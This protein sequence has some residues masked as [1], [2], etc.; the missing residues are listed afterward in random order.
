[1]IEQLEPEAPSA[2]P[3]HRD[4]SPTNRRPWPWAAPEIPP[5]PATLPGGK[6][7]P[8][9][10]VVTPS[11]NQGQFI[12]QT[13]LSVLNQNYPNLEFLVV[14][15]GS[16]DQT[17]SVVE[18][19]R[20]R[21]SYF[22]SEKDK[23][24]SNA[25]NKGFAR[26]TGEILTWL[27]SDDML[28]PDALAAMALAFHT[29]GADMVA[30][31]CSQHIDGKIVRRDM[32][33][34][35]DGIL[36]LDEILDI[37]GCWLRGQF[38]HQP[39]VMFTR[40]LWERAGAHVDE[41][42]FYS[43]DYEL[44]LRFAEQK[45]RLHPI[46]RSI[47]LYRVHEDQKSFSVGR[48]KPEL[49]AVRDSYLKRTGR[50]LKTHGP[51][52]H[53]LPHLRIVMFNDLGGVGGAGIGHQRLATALATAGHEVIPLA[54]MPDLVS[55]QLS[56]DKILAAI[57]ETHPN[58]VVVGNLHAAKLEPG[59][60][61][62]IAQRW[63][64]IQV[65]HDFYSLTGRCAYPGECDK[66]IAGCD[67]TC[68]TAHEYPVLE[69]RLIRAAWEKKNAAMI[70][71]KAPILAAVSDWAE[72]VV[73]KRFENGPRVI[74]LRNGVPIDI[75]KPRDKT[76]C[77]EM[78][79]LPQ[80]RFIVLFSA[81]HLSDRRKGLHHLMEALESLKLPYLLAVCIGHSDQTPEAMGFEIRSVGFVADPQSLAMLYSAADLF[82]GPSLMETFGQVF[83]EAAACGTPSIGYSDA[84]G[85][86]E[87]LADGVSGLLA[88]PT[89]SQALAKSIASLHA[90]PH[91]RRDM[92]RWGRLWVEN[93]FSF[94]TVYQ[95]C[96]SELNRIGLISELGLPP[97][98]KFF[99]ASVAPP[100]VKYLEPGASPPRATL[101]AF[102]GGGD[103]A[104][105]QSRL[106]SLEAERDSLR[107]SY[108]SVTQ[109]RLWRT[110]SWGYRIYMRLLGSRY[111]PGFARRAIAAVGGWLSQRPPA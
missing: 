47:C 107:M 96:F 59:L 13:I 111:I 102:A 98:V 38:F 36:P 9:I 83:V 70:S 14:D 4:A 76:M 39:E 25:I 29:S 17:V 49:L 100:Q 15:G 75:F 64:T 12:E 94:Q 16:K 69:P 65:L 48:F 68:P 72:D 106:S 54:V 42:L 28:E 20:D 92:A 3:T 1:L 45:A 5:L 97:K 57:A 51:E 30:G 82:V 24:Q 88:S 80:D 2:L 11:F 6:P 43:M 21:I 101:P 35:G 33:S 60:L 41:S 61:G 44:W 86:A 19:F 91:L 110:V 93:E 63:P 23:G 62:L 103:V 104:T 67:H 7:W 31:I 40:D 99:H 34:C 26:A 10:S 109:T 73:R 85:V 53:R 22:V 8:R 18:K 89:D 71:P 78:L 105:L 56:S 84:G 95:R 55:S 66:Y 50:A 79:G 52:I 32:T 58:L 90:D 27:N 77:R 74:G 37:E 87:A 108:Y 81:S 46:G